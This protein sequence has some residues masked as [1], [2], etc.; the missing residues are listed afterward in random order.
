[1][2]FIL[3]QVFSDGKEAERKIRNP[4]L[5]IDLLNEKGNYL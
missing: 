3:D 2:E 5:T 1:M 4:F